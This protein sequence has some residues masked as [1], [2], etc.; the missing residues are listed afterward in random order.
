MDQLWLDMFDLAEQG[1]AALISGLSE[2]KAALQ[3]PLPAAT[4]QRVC[5]QLQPPGPCMHTS[6]AFKGLN[7]RAPPETFSYSHPVLVLR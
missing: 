5:S 4:S 7:V 3:S 6:A 1:W 2:S